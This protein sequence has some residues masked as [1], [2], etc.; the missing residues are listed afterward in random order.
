[1][2]PLAIPSFTSCTITYRHVATLGRPF[3]NPR[4]RSPVL[5]ACQAWMLA[6][7][8]PKEPP[9]RLHVAWK[10]DDSTLVA[11]LGTKSLVGRCR[12]TPGGAG[13]NHRI[14]RQ[15]PAPGP[16]AADVVV[17]ACGGPLATAKP[18]HD[19]GL[20]LGL[21]VPSVSVRNVLGRQ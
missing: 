14:R 20:C 9:M 8:A 13:F 12:Q 16:C 19:P 10:R 3:Q 7:L 11:N 6:T 21:R 1:V 4:L 2:G 17:R 5:F 18:C 15:G